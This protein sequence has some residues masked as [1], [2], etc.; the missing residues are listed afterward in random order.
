MQQV[1][2]FGLRRGTKESD[3]TK[4]EVPFD[5]SV[6]DLRRY[7][8]RFCKELYNWPDTIAL[9]GGLDRTEEGLRLQIVERRP[10]TDDERRAY[11]IP[12]SVENAMTDGEVV[13]S[14]EIV[15]INPHR[16][17][18]ICK[19]VSA[20]CQRFM[21]ALVQKI[22]TQK[23]NAGD[24]FRRGP[25]ASDRQAEPQA[26]SG[27]V[28]EPQIVVTEAL[29]L[30]TTL[31]AFEQ[32]LR[33][34][35]RSRHPSREPSAWHTDG[36]GGL[37]I[38]YH[39]PPD[40][41]ICFKATI[42]EAGKMTIT[43]MTYPRHWKDYFEELIEAVRRQWLSASLPQADGGAEVLRIRATPAELRDFIKWHW[44]GI[45]GGY[46][47]ELKDCL[48]PVN[49]PVADLIREY[50]FSWRYSV[51]FPYLPHATARFPQGYP[52]SWN[53]FVYGKRA[54]F[55][56]IDVTIEA[57]CAVEL[58][59][60]PK[61]EDD[62]G[63]AGYIRNLS[64]AIQ[65]QFAK[66]RL[67]DEHPEMSHIPNWF[68]LRECGEKLTREGK[69]PFTRKQLIDCVHEKHP[70]RKESALHPMIQG[71]T[72]N[73]RGGAP[74]GIGKNMFY[75]VSRGQYVLYDPKK[76]GQI[77]KGE[78]IKPSGAY[79]NGEREKMDWDVFIS[80]AWEDK[81]SFAR[82]LAKA[83]EAKGLRVW[84]DEFTLRVGDRLR[85]S[86]DY[87]LAK[88]RYGVVILSP[89][90]FGKEW[91]QKELDGLV[92][93]ET[94][95]DKVVLPVWHNISVDQ[96]REYSPTLADRIAVSSDR[97]LEH[98]VSELLKVLQPFK[99]FEPEMILIPAGEFLMGSDPS[100][101][102]DARP[103]E[104]PQHTVYLPDYHLA[105]TPVTNAQ[106]AAFVRAT[107]HRL[108]EHWRLIG[109]QP[110]RGKENHPV[111]YV[112]RDDVI[113]YCRWLSEVTGK[114]YRLPS[115][116]EWEKAA[117]GTD[118]RIYPWGNQWDP[119]RCNSE[120][121]GVGDTTPVGAYPEGASPYGVLD[122]AG[123]VEE[124]PR[125]F[126]RDYPYDPDDGREDLEGP[127]GVT[128]SGSWNSKRASNRCAFRIP[129][130]ALGEGRSRNVGAR[131]LGFRVAASPGS[132]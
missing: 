44:H 1:G 81:E 47:L 79:K 6:E 119:N 77:T 118:G 34:Y 2:F 62:P 76:H 14:I 41:R 35:Q 96:I 12:D 130:I 91:P 23:L 31:E 36:S 84:F 95:G 21:D 67:K 10:A 55:G 128:R 99:L 120:E 94:A 71:M 51:I 90:F 100:V 88:S 85:R 17:N 103:D 9:S 7:V 29:T 38:Y 80:H 86:I 49:L 30:D 59:D 101:D 58:V 20:D 78:T 32:W 114:S 27:A 74:G 122:M 93:R 109:G 57:Y 63:V 110:P 92:A 117:R 73:A 83:L 132:P 15:R 112:S 25:M 11:G 123:N 46:D 43:K 111:V 13:G 48:S 39:A 113:A 104:Q 40:R 75:R 3:I 45:S 82:P 116:A 22:E 131:H 37:R 70:E 97:G 126:W 4:V 53:F 107:G 16:A 65:K 54:T 115:E 50:H 69:S 61:A 56:E 42:P 125:S 8:L 89:H 18:L 105:K 64:D 98:V 5:G 129:S 66:R 28:N 60:R 26:D 102:E 124:R 19:S 68:L 108:P 127:G 121:G 52:F 24:V 33:S 87:G 72:V 106:Y